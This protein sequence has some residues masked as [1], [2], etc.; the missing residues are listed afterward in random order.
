MFEKLLDQAREKL[1]RVV[2]ESAEN[3][4]ASVSEEAE[5]SF[6][7]DV[8]VAESPIRVL[9]TV[10]VFSSDEMNGPILPPVPVDVP[11]FAFYGPIGW[12]DPYGDEAILFLGINQFLYRT[13][14]FAKSEGAIVAVG[15]IDAVLATDFEI[16]QTIKEVAEVVALA[17]G[18]SGIEPAEFDE[19]PEI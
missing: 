9:A 14:I 3:L 12:I 1:S 18:I 10:R 11:V 7:L 8:P 5:N 16:E 15:Y 2:K 13:R 4:Q 19:E 17:R 6:W